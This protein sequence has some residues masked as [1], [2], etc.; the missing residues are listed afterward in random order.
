M[1]L[2]FTYSCSFL[3]SRYSLV[4]FVVGA[5]QVPLLIA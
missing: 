5:E 2:L 4:M 1:G 3:L